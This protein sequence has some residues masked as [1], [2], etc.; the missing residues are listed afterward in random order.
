MELLCLFEEFSLGGVYVTTLWR[1]LYGTSRAVQ[2]MAQV[3]MPTMVSLIYINIFDADAVLTLVLH[4]FNNEHDDGYGKYKSR[5]SR[6]D[7]RDHYRHPW[8][9]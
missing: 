3:E 5:Q 2:E 8:L 6:R 1:Q 9:T 4:S 7:E